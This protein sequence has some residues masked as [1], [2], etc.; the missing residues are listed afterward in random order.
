MRTKIPDGNLQQYASLIYSL[1]RPD[2]ARKQTTPQN[3]ATVRRN[4]QNVGRENMRQ[5]LLE[6]LL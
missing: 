3:K 4:F 6:T 5:K 1:L 2:F